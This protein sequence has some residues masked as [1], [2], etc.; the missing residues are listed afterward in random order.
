MLHR[1]AAHDP[2]ELLVHILDGRGRDGQKVEVRVIVHHDVYPAHILA[3]LA[4]AALNIG[5]VSVEG[6]MFA[7]ADLAGVVADADLSVHGLFR[8]IR[9]RRWTGLARRAAPSCGSPP[10][11]Q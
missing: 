7:V 6:A 1:F 9:W 10:A 2:G 4:F 11:R 8:A 3:G 5:A